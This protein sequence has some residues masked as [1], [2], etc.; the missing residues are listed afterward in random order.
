MAENRLAC[1]LDRLLA[2]AQHLAP[3]GAE[4]W[5][6]AGMK[7]YSPGQL[8]AA[9]AAARDAEHRLRLT[10]DSSACMADVPALQ[11][12]EIIWCD[13]FL[14][15]QPKL[16]RCGLTARWREHRGLAAHKHPR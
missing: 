16:S 11:A 1:A 9:V 5:R 2:Q 8:T 7:R 14:G 6:A 12:G 15:L 13:V 10:D 4:F 3:P